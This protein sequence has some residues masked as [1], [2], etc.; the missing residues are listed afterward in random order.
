[1]KYDVIVIGA[2]FSGLIAA[3]QACANGKKVLVISKGLGEVNLT[4]GC[5]DILGYLPGRENR[6]ITNV[7]KNLQLLIAQMPVHPYAKVGMATLEDSISYFL[8]LAG[9]M[10]Y[11]FQGDG[12]TNYLL[13][14]GF[15]TV[16]PTALVPATMA[17]GDIRAEGDVLVLGFEELT[18]F[19]PRLITDRLNLIRS[20]LN[21]KGKWSSR[22]LSL[23]S[24]GQGI[25]PLKAAKWLE[26]KHNLDQFI[27]RIKQGLQGETKVALPAILGVDYSCDIFHAVTE[28]LGCP[29]FEIPFGQPTV[30]GVRL[31]NMLLCYVKQRGV[32]VQLGSPV[33]KAEPVK[34]HLK[35]LVD[36]PGRATA[37]TC[38]HLVI[39]TGGVYGKGLT[40]ASGG[41][42]ENILGL[43]VVNG[44]GLNWQT[45][46]NRFLEWSKC[47]YNGVGVAVEQDLRP[48]VD[49]GERERFNGEWVVGRSLA[50]YDPIAEKSGL[51]VALATGFAAG[52][53]LAGGS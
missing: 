1:M 39:A 24:T 7:E 44:I 40:V 9:K 32:K 20:R 29:V 10:G 52:K 34:D 11:P 30:S 33:L 28:S 17:M 41:I 48:I 13:P 3:A 47:L 50:G 21:L 2:G 51:G 26:N 5:V 25:S 42:K 37:Y 15:G 18:D 16:R 38:Q 35:V 49:S 43:P 22:M 53:A 27:N 46:G 8:E 31:N 19:H 4:S 23:G 6:C 45:P 36:T 12:R 14:T